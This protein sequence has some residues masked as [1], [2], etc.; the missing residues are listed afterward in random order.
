MQPEFGP[1][2]SPRDPQL[3]LWEF[4]GGRADLGLGRYAQAIGEEHRAIDDNFKTYVPHPVLVAAYALRGQA[5]AAQAELAEAIYLNPRMTSI[6]SLIPLNRQ[7]LALVDGCEKAGL[8][9]SE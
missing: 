7:I 4:V 2:L 9:R 6:T 1:P 5:K 8:R 3:G